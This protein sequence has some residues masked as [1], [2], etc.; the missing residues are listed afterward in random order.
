MKTFKVAASE[1]VRKPDEV[2]PY[3]T[4]LKIVE[5]RIKTF[6]ETA[7]KIKSHR[8]DRANYQFFVYSHKSGLV[9]GKVNEGKGRSKRSK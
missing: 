5:E 6:E 9:G 1:Y 8:W 4:Y 2:K 7:G 3:G